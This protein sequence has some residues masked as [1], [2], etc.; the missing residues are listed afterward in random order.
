MTEDAT[1]KAPPAN[2]SFELASKNTSLSFQRTRL[3][4][5]RTLMSVI[6]TS[7]SLISFGFTIFKLAQSLVEEKILKVREGSVP[8]FGVALV[9]LGV[10]MLVIGIIYHVQFM[11]GLRSSRKE[12]IEEGLIH[13]KNPFPI[14]FIL[15]TAVIL[16]LL[17]FSAIASMVFGIGPFS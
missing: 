17:G 10:L 1:P 16:L 15:V 12:M 9:L 6:R 5:D 2:A 14:S 4:A 13:G 7:L 11:V 3:S 8:H